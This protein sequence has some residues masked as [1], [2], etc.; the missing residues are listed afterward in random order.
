MSAISYN[1]S[2]VTPGVAGT[3]TW[4]YTGPDF[5]DTYTVTATL[6]FV[7]NN[8]YYFG[9]IKDIVSS[10]ASRNGSVNVTI[11]QAEL[12]NAISDSGGTPTANTSF[13]VRFYVADTDWIVEDYTSYPVDQAVSA[14]SAVTLSKSSAGPSE[15]IT[16]SWS[17]ASAGWRNNITGY[18]IYRATSANGSYSL[19]KTVSTSATSGSTSV[20]A[21]STNGG[22]YYYKVLTLGTI[23]NSGQSSAAP[24]VTVSYSA[25]TIGTL[26][27]NKTHVTGGNVTLSWSGSAGTNN[28]IT[29]YHVY[30]GNTKYGETTGTSMSVPA[31]TTEGGTVTYKVYAI[32]AYSNSQ[33][34]N[35]VTIYTI[36]G[37]S[38][39]TLVSCTPAAPEPEGTVRIEWSGASGGSYNNIAGYSIYVKETESDSYTLLTTVN[40]TSSSGYIEVTAPATMG[41]Q[42]WYQVAT[43]GEYSSSGRSTA[44]GSFSVL[45]Y[46]QHQP[47]TNLA[48]TAYTAVQSQQVTLSWDTAIAGSGNT[49][50][51]Y[52]VYRSTSPIEGF[53]SI[54]TTS[55][56]AMVVTAPS[57]AGAIYYYRVKTLA[58][59]SDYNSTLSNEY[60][61]LQTDADV[62]TD[63]S[64]PVSAAFHTAVKNGNPQEIKIHFIED[65]EDFFGADITSDGLHYETYFC[66]EKDL[67]IGLTPSA[68]VS[69]T[70]F[71]DDGRLNSMHWGKF[72]VDIGVHLSANEI[73]WARLGV[74]YADR[75]RRVYTREVE[76]SGVDAMAYLCEKSTANMSITFPITLAD[77]LDAV[78]TFAGIEHRITGFLNQGRTLTEEDDVYQYT[79]VR[80]VLGFIA[81][82][83]CANAMIAYDGKLIFG[84]LNET[85]VL[86][87]SSDYSYCATDEYTVHPIN[88]LQ[89]RNSD[90]DIGVI[91]G[92]GTNGYVIQENPC[93][94]FSSNAEGQT[95]AKTIYDRLSAVA[96]YVPMELEWF[97]DWSYRPGDVINVNYDGIVYRLPIFHMSLDW[98]GSAIIGVESTGNEYRAEMTAQNRESYQIGRKLTEIKKTIDGIQIQVSEYSGGNDYYTLIEQNSREIEALASSVENIESDTGYL[99]ERVNQAELNVSP[100]AIVST[101]RSSVAYQ[102]DL[103][104]KVN[105]ATLI[106]EINQ[107]AEGVS[108]SGEK[109][110]LKG[111]ITANGYFQILQDGT[112]KAVNADISGTLKAGNWTFSTNG[113]VY[114]SGS[115]TARISVSGDTAIY[116]TQGLNA[117]YGADADHTTTIQG[118]YVKLFCEDAG[119]G[120]LVC[121]S[122]SRNLGTIDYED[123]TLICDKASNG[124]ADNSWTGSKGNIGT[125]LYRWDI[126]WIKLIHTS[127]QWTVSSRT[128]KHDI[129]SLPE[130]GD[131][132]DRLEP[133]QF[134][135]NWE[136]KPT[137]GL[138]LEDTAEVLP[139]I[140]ALP[141]ENE[142]GSLNYIALIPVLLKEVQSLRKRIK[143]LESGM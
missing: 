34:S 22:V 84:W 65:D 70:L 69:F 112:M 120:V 111:T 35:T 126:G 108:I 24:S 122:D 52:E 3:V 30:Q 26:S 91:V 143:Y 57:S 60:V 114:Q 17:G 79:T 21:P 128:Q 102:N 137:F 86:L 5:V 55:T 133:V 100:T 104:E 62:I 132:I 27:A 61:A 13:T 115:N 32:G 106:S 101:V 6:V 124:E 138:I 118:N 11:T 119:Y 16:L 107:S 140:C 66:S 49:I 77:L 42:R 40:S 38:A 25:P 125:R 109:I 116:R 53:V 81:E 2:S 31:S 15:A 58:S 78:C 142:E 39:P 99:E 67:T 75:P 141:G 136:T 4:A 93:L 135:Y 127:A 134:T 20:D 64:V 74:F 45:V 73:E 129:S 98:L 72:T 8:E 117:Q 68:N 36:T 10:T 87:T 76:V 41:A 12:N 37:V 18:Q 46:A 89:I 110:N 130:M 50:T 96:A 83:A 131:I 14:P 113:G 95:P 56:L 97:G 139:E 92:T 19:L 29:T 123:P 1:R 82:A 47:P 85:N 105:V 7:V 43:I 90:N 44:T 94:V 33:A 80:E 121:N 51:G 59:N 63:Y 103:G 9:Y 48:L 71:N 88:K 54:G 23:S 28:P